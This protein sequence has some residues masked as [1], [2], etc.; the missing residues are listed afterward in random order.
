MACEQ[1]GQSKFLFKAEGGAGVFSLFSPIINSIMW[2]CI[3][4]S[5]LKNLS[6]IGDTGDQMVNLSLR[7]AVKQA[8]KL[9]AVEHLRADMTP[10]KM[11]MGELVMKPLLSQLVKR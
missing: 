7:N 10:S 4:G 11:E 2:A 9:R 8:T 6:H 5:A 3:F 1:V